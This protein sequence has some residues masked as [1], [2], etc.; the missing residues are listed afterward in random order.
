MIPAVHLLQR[1]RDGRAPRI[2]LPLAIVMF[3]LLCA[4]VAIFL[5]R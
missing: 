3:T 1:R 4:G 2:A 5:A